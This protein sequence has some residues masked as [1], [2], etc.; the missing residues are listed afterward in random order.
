VQIERSPI[1]LMKD[2]IYTNGGVAAKKICPFGHNCC[3]LEMD[4]FSNNVL[5]AC[6]KRNLFVYDGL[7][8]VLF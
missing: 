5:Y 4:L 3:P 7:W 2:Y 6:I 8:C 1:L